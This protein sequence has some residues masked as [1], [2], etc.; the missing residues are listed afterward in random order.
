[1]TCKV[2]TSSVA[3]QPPNILQAASQRFALGLDRPV[4]NV[5]QKSSVGLRTRMI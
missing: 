4:T 1:M 2:I 3:S 5:I